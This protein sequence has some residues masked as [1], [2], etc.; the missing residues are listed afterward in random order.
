MDD[1]EGIERG[2]KLFGSFWHPGNNP[3]GSGVSITGAQKR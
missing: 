2:E 3:A 1:A